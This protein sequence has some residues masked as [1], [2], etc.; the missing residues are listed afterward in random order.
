VDFYRPRA[1]LQ[2]YALFNPHATL[3]LHAL[4]EDGV[5]HTTWEASDPTWRKWVPSQP[6]SPH[7]YTP[8]RFAQLLMAYLREERQGL[9]ARSVRE[10]LA[11]FDGL[12]GTTARKAVLEAAGLQRAMLEPIFPQALFQ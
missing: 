11:E 2:G 5:E 9:A 8:E 12:S 4:Q 6:T 1:L 3:A 7:W 10:L